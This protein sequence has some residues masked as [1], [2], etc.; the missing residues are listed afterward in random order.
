VRRGDSL[1]RIAGNFRVTVN[2]IKQWNG[3]D[4]QRYLQPGQR[5][6]LHVDVTAQSGG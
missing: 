2:Q 6:V 4:G 5:L 3:L 1:A